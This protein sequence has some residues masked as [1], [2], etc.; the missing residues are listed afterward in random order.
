MLT[1]REN[2]VRFFRNE[3]TQWLPS[4]LDF[5]QFGPEEVIENVCRGFVS[6]QNP[7]PREKY[8][9]RG[10]FGLDWV[11]EPEVGGAITVGKFF[12]DIE[13]W[14][15]YVEWPD[16][17]AIDWE[18]VRERNSE[19]LDT[20]KL[21]RSSIFTGFYERLISFIGF[22]DAAVALVDEDQQEAVHALF[23]RLADLYV[24]FIGRMHKYF[25]VELFELHD[26]WGSQRSPFFSL[27][28]HTEMLLPYIKKVVEGA[29]REGCFIEM[30]S[31]GN[32][33]PLMPNFVA[34]GL[35]TWRGQASAINKPRIVANWGDKFK[36]GVEIRPEPGASD[37]EIRTLVRE[38]REN[39]T[40]KKI[41][42]VMSVLMSP[43][44]RDFIEKE[45]FS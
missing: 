45:L 38:F 36:F 11:F 19:Y 27:D 33:E 12:E 13:D 23:S 6:Q 4:S 5:K 39:Y 18:A 28:T 7:F 37:E 20:D 15:K 31:C 30:H 32:V 40:G 35:D 16:L 1:P 25:G 24:D 34:S 44:Q 21:L 2:F 29:H 10:Y 42:V 8:G 14:E 26:D 9:G 17:D 22:E 43:A 3:P 41:W